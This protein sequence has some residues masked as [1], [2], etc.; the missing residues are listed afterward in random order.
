MKKFLALVL[1]L[2]MLFCCVPF[3]AFSINASAAGE[4]NG[5]TGD[6]TWTLNGALLTISGNGSME[7]YDFF[8]QNYAPWGTE[9][10]EVIIEEG[11]TN[12]GNDS[13]TFCEALKKVTFPSSVLEINSRMFDYCFA[14]EEIIVDEGNQNFLSEEGVLFNKEKNVLLF[15]P[16]SNSIKNYT[17]PNSVK[18]ISGQ[19]FYSAKNL[20]KVFIGDSVTEIGSYAFAYCEALDTVE[21]GK[22]VEKISINA[23]CDIETLK[24]ISIEAEEVEIDDNA[25]SNTGYYNDAQN[26]ENGALYIGKILIAVSDDIFGEFVIKEGTVSLL[27]NAISNKSG[28]TSIVLPNSM[29]ALTSYSISD[30]SLLESIVIP[31]SITVVEYHAILRC[32]ALKKI[33]FRDDALS[34]YTKDIEYSNFYDA[35]WVF[36]FCDE[37]RT[38]EYS[39]DCDEYCDYCGNFRYNAHRYTHSFDTECDV[40]L[41][42]KNAEN[43]VLYEIIDNEA[44]IT[45]YNNRVVV[46]EIVI[47]EEIDGYTVTAINNEA[48]TWC[49]TLKSVV[50]PDSVKT[51]GDNA[52]SYCYSLTQ[53]DLGDGVTTVGD[54]A[55]S[56]CEAL[57]TVIV[58]EGLRTLENGAFSGCKALTTVSLAD[59]LTHI[60]ENAFIYCSSITSIVIPST[61]IE[62]GRE[63]FA[64]CIALTS[65]EIPNSVTT[66]NDSAFS[67]C[68]ALKQIS[69]GNNVTVLGSSVFE[70]TAYCNDM[71]NWENG[72][73][74]INNYLIAV[75]TDFSG[76]FKVKEGTVLMPNLAFYMCEG[77]TSVELPESITSIPM[78]AFAYCPSLKSITLK[79][80]L[81]SVETLA[82]YGSS[83]FNTVYYSGSKEDAEK[84]DIAQNNEELKNAIW[85]YNS[86]NTP[87]F[88]AGDID[89]NETVNAADLALLKKVIAGLKQINDADVVNPDVD[90]KGDTPNAADLALLKKIIA[91]IV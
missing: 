38:H 84:I 83:T 67:G 7:D 35:E 80:S 72:G 25:F 41:K 24:N 26:W 5:T 56:G 81:K 88:T 11:V 89:G 53:V 8:N 91:G 85:F 57:K 15:F 73:L 76:T 18:T 60:K 33:Y 2:T 61:V 70:N 77:I 50:L 51:I 9:I 13:F 23:F 74:Y 17:V 63:A 58:G 69:I 4:T 12:I 10:V 20:E 19:A 90:G 87:V 16:Q 14:L 65:V 22:N 43:A 55:F 3:G 40:C 39:N 6:C 36:D 68:T 54:H 52:F 86:A 37:Q 28:I 46:G 34:L 31:S 62:I 66:V 78:G 29:T 21:I 44:I 64:F 71:Q 48:F 49:N 79:D 42:K 45:D 59:G 32:S 82:F 1:T 27:R 30:C 47:P 75:K